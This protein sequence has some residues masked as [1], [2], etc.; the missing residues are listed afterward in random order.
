MT[1]NELRSLIRE[2]LLEELA[3]PELTESAGS[4][5]AYVIFNNGFAT[6]LDDYYLF[7][8]TA[9]KAAAIDTLIEEV[10]YRIQDYNNYSNTIYCYYVNLDDYDVTLEE[11]IEASEHDGGVD[12]H[13]RSPDVVYALAAMRDNE[14][15]LYEFWPK[16]SEDY[17]SDFLELQGYDVEDILDKEDTEDYDGETF[18]DLV[19]KLRTD[20]DFEDWVSGMIESEIDI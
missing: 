13:F 9:N 18:A 2:C 10:V 3:K 1:K 6:D 15:P 8:A 14:K 12:L 17:Y 4:N 19:G 5:N 7:A 16:S 11:L 20:K